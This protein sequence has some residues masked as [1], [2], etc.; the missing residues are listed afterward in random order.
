MV[1]T[2][3]FPTAMPTHAHIQG[4]L[5]FMDKRERLSTLKENRMR[6][7]NLRDVVKSATVEL[8]YVRLWCTSPCAVEVIVRVDLRHLLTIIDT[9][10]ACTITSRYENHDNRYL[11]SFEMHAYMWS[12]MTQMTGATCAM[13]PCSGCRTHCPNCG[14]LGPALRAH[15]FNM[16]TIRNIGL[17][18]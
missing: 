1:V 13:V 12:K 16:D 14:S 8:T 6:L 15:L 7:E 17:L 5:V 18:L 2:Y 4:E 3:W 10:P 11:T 9:T